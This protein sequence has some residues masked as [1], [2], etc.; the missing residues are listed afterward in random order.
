MERRYFVC[1]V[2]ENRPTGSIENVRVLTLYSKSEE[3]PIGE[4]EKNRKFEYFVIQKVRKISFSALF[5]HKQR[6]E[7]TEERFFEKFW[8][9]RIFGNV[10]RWQV[11][12]NGVSR[13]STAWPKQD[14]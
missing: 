2:S 13:H 12:T 7:M 3:F 11:F 8:A 9:L 6:S 10:A 4:E 1:G 5:Q 14:A